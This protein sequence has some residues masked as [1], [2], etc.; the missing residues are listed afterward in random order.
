MI[1]HNIRNYAI[2]LTKKDI[3]KIALI[4]IISVGVLFAVI[5]LIM[6]IAPILIGAIV[7]IPWLGAA[8][9]D[10]GDV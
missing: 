7:F 1:S 5:W 9:A 6:E 10:G 3:L 8:L 4:I 2:M